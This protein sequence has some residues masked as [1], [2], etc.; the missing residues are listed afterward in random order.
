MINLQAIIVFTFANVISFLGCR[1]SGI[2]NSILIMKRSRYKEN[3]YIMLICFAF[4][5]I[6]IENSLG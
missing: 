3:G 2:L 6:T 5:I 4:D 1:A